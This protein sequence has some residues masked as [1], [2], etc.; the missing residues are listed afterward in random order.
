MSMYIIRA[1]AAEQYTYK[2]RVYFNPSLGARY[3]VTYL[4]AW[5]TFVDHLNI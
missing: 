1:A 5:S 4:G 2:G 3:I